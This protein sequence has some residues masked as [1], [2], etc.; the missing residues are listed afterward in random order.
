[1]KLFFV[2]LLAAFAAAAPAT[3]QGL[4]FGVQVAGRVQGGCR[5]AAKPAQPVT[6]RCSVPLSTTQAVQMAGHLRVVTVTPAV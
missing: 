3:A 4:A 5:A 6:L 1:M 2:T